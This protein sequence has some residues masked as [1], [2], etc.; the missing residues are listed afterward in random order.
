M[1][2]TLIVWRLAGSIRLAL[3]VV[4]DADGKGRSMR[5][6]QAGRGII[7]TDAAAVLQA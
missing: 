5:S 3:P 4:R 7:Y 2:H 1:C 6:C